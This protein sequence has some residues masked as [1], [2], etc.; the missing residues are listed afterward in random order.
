MLPLLLFCVALLAGIFAEQFMV[1]DK[2][3]QQDIKA[4]SRVLDKKQAALDKTMSDISGQLA[5]LPENFDR[6]LFD[7]LKEYNELFDQ[8]ELSI[9]VTRN[10]Q[11]VYWTDRVVAFV[12]EIAAAQ[13]G[14]VQLPNG[15]FVLSRK[16]AGPYEI[17][18]L[19]LI[20]YNYQIRNNYL[21][22]RF[23]K[24]FNFPNDFEILFY[25]SDHADPIYNRDNQF[26]FSVKPAGDMLSR[27]SDLYIP[28][29]M[30]LLAL[31]FLF[32]S[33]YRV[34]NHLYHK[35][36]LVKLTLLL[37][38]LSAIYILM[39][40][41]Q[42]PHS[43]YQLKLF[44]PKYFAY[45]KYWGSLGE[46]LLFSTFVLFWSINYFRTFDLRD[47][48]KKNRSTRRICLTIG[49]LFVAFL[50]IAIRHLMFILVMNSSISFAVYQVSDMNL[51][52]IA[53]FTAIGFIFLSFLLV[54]YRTTQIFRKYSGIGEFFVI[55]LGISCLLFLFLYDRYPGEQWYMSLFFMLI[56][57]M[58]FIIGRRN[59]LRHRLTVIIFYVIAFTLFTLINLLGFVDQSEKRMQKLMVVNLSEEHDPIAELYLIDIDQK[60]KTD[61]ILRKQLEGGL[62]D[63]PDYLDRKYF[64]GYFREYEFQATVCSS[65]DSLFVQ[66]NNEFKPC[67][68]F[69]DMMI[70]QK[71]FQLSDL[72]F[73]FVENMNGRITYLGRYEWAIGQEQIRVYIELNS[74]MLSEG[75]G[76]PELL[77]PQHS[78]ESRI[79]NRFSFAKYNNG[80]LVDRSGDFLYTLNT[81]AYKL[82]ENEIE[83]R[84]WEGYEHCIYH[85]GNR[86]FIIVSR[87]QISLYDYFISFPYIFVFFFMLGLMINYLARPYLNL[88]GINNSLRSK[89]QLTIIGVVLFTLLIVGSGTITYNVFQYRNNHRQ[90]LIDKINSISVEMDLLMS[91]VDD[92]KQIDSEFLNH[93][94]LRVSEVF[95]IDINLYDLS[96]TLRATSRPEVYER[97]L[98]SPS[99]DNNALHY[100]SL[101]QPTRFIHQENVGQLD[102]LSAYVPLINRSGKNFGYIN[103][104]YFTHERKF[105]QQ[106]TTFIL[107]FINIY[108]F[109]LM[110]S[111]FAA[112]YISGR[113]TDPLKL[114]RENLRN[115]QLGKNTKPILYK[116]NDEIGLLVAEYNNKLNELAYS[117][118]LLA[119]NEREMAWR[120]MAKQIA[121][122]I[123]NPLTP[124]KLNIQFLQHTSAN[125]SDYQEKVKKVTDLLIE[126]ID[127][128]SAIA[129]AFSNFAQ[130][131]KAKNEV[132]HLASKLKETIELYENTGQ[133]E[134][135]I[136]FSDDAKNVEVNADKEQFSRAIINLMRNA[137]QSIP[138]D[139][140]GLIA[141]TLER[142][143]RYGLIKIKDNGKGIDES[144]R[145][146][147]FTPNFTTKTSGTGL[148]L[149]IT[150]NIV[151]NFKGEIGF[152]SQSGIGSTFYIKIPLSERINQ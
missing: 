4:F 15:W 45:S 33:F 146:S 51:Y 95:W 16:S 27:Y 148:G 13:T 96:G 57:G 108:V 100:L 56:I 110:A 90:D 85:Q 141:V 29:S 79:R 34:N 1:S 46:F 17:H 149:A 112:Y 70:E 3:K 101:Y 145:E 26:L 41:L 40:K 8:K 94:L 109:L 81:E 64:S 44:S 75:T 127:N 22:N 19:V 77:L 121:H 60:I 50:F 93:E 106:M 30:Y 32:M 128:L 71:G 124:M 74:R 37:A 88:S 68:P 119:R 133:C 5:L 10:D 132:F 11:A 151:Q 89:I 20:K 49:F 97:G 92:F 118:E 31:G 86:N 78:I 136:R 83:F 142:E 62:H 69:F 76:F 18:G 6:L 43:M 144:L 36:Q 55:F 130:I 111:I 99:M 134:I 23:A 28:I 9:I 61:T 103:I 116:S 150:K 135:S 80:E 143:G 48:I 105:R 139:R 126:Q 122:E 107:A 125:T 72:N 63:I 140:K 2:I 42:L 38:G 21:D 53:G 117:A 91:Q 39:N 137:I 123:K 120:E 66:P 73:H 67:F 115:M 24:G 59:F 54:S 129:S 58:G 52:S 25:D 14:L 47:S 152:E 35:W 102:Y 131:P 138:Q 84:A 7:M 82:S 147:I 113:I 114:I 98:I 65:Y 104:P 12:P 87:P